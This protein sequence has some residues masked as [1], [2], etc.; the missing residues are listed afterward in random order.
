MFTF[1]IVKMKKID[2][3][4]TSTSNEYYKISFSLICT[5]QL[6]FTLAMS[7]RWDWIP[8]LSKLEQYK[9]SY[10]WL[11]TWEN[12]KI[13]FGI[14]STSEEYYKISFSL[15]CTVQ[16]LFILAIIQ[17]W[18]Y[19]PSLIKYDQYKVSYEWLST[20]EHEKINFQ[21]L[22]TSDVCITINISSIVTVQSLYSSAMAHRWE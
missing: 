20:C 15:I 4:P 9:V 6:L 3:G 22:S 18:D 7:H 1:P 17:R 8:S 11:S 14:I 12:E 5:V 21:I 13:N 19:I 16:L 10:E 2:F